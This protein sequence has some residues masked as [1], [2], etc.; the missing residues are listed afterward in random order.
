MSNQNPQDLN[1]DSKEL[2]PDGTPK[3]TE[4]A[5]L[6]KKP[7][8]S[9]DVDNLTPEQAAK[10]WKDKADASTRGFHQFKTDKEKE[11]EE[12]K[13]KIPSAQELED[14][15]SK[16]AN[17]SEFENLIPN[18]DL[19][20]DEA[21]ANLKIF[22]RN[23]E[24]NILGKIDKDPAILDSRRTFNEKKWE[25]AFNKVAGQFTELTGFREEFKKAYFQADNVPDNIDQILTTLAKSYLFDRA[26]ELGA[27][28]EQ[29]RQERVELER[30]GRGGAD[31]QG[32][33]TK[34]TLED[35][36]FLQK[37]NP[38]KFSE[39]KKEFDEDMASGKLSE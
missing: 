31:P 35:W 7:D 5:E 18:F 9:V 3:G 15:A 14:A 37:T 39:L 33:S 20:D 32:P 17:A 26:K 4:G 24:K 10:Y 21:K 1:L 11:I 23:I 16:A 28:E 6:P 8:G 25:S 29:E 19:L 36:L 13:S 22:Y 30:A 12:L 2:N 34:R 27:K 38:V